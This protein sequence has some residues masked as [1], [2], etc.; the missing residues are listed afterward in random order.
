MVMQRFCLLLFFQLVMSYKASSELF[1]FQIY[2]SS[3]KFRESI[4]TGNLTFDSDSYVLADG[5][6]LKFKLAFTHEDL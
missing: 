3:Q 5:M 6:I 4:F 2:K 1:S